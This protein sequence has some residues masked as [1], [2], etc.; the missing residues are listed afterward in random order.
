MDLAQVGQYAVFCHSHLTTTAT[1]IIIIYIKSERL[2]L[3]TM[4]LM[5][6]LR[7]SSKM[8]KIKKAETTLL[9]KI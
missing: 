2:M 4:E 6:F 8:P 3:C 7:T 5:Y 9:T 1:I